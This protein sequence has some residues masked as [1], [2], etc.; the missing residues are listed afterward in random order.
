M[1]DLRVKIKDFELKN[2]IIPASGTF[3][4]G[5]EFAQIYD[6]NILGSMSVKG[7]TLEPRFGNPL[8]RIA[9]TPSG[10]LNCV[11]L[12]NPGAEEVKKTY[13][14]LIKNVYKDKIII[15]I[16]GSDVE[17]YVRAAEILTDDEIVGAAELNISCPNVKEGGIAFG[18]DE[19]KAAEVISK[20][21]KVCKV[22]LIVKL[23]PNVTD[24]T[25]IARVAENEGA[26][27][28]SLINT[29]L[30]MAI[31]YKT[32]RVITSNSYAGLSGAAVKP[33]ALR[34]VHQT[35]KAVKIPVIGMGGIE[36]A[37]DVIEFMS[38]GATAVMIGSRNLVD[39]Y[40]C[41]NIIEDLPI[42][43]KEIGVDDIKKI[44]GRTK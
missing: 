38:A 44:I 10:M 21:R 13:Y 23:T 27:A 1:I 36:N 24:I 4:Y 2:P 35:A 42:L 16:G 12:Q 34:M 30:G 7:T 18:A 41:K 43:L 3:G 22:P 40:V 14:K 8:P 9:E 33:V 19:E 17:S 39:P 26:D 32:G 11:G 15:N 37:K 31:D 6:I 29:L 25:K 5:L 20:V 28:V